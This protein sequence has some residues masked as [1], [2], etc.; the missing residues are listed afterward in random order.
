MD[1]ASTSRKRSVGETGGSPQRPPR[2]LTGTALSFDLAQEV[3]TLHQEETWHRGD[4]NART[5]IEEPG[6]RVVLPVLR[7]GSRVREHRNGR[8][9]VIPTLA[10][11]IRAQSPA[12][13][14]GPVGSR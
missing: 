7:A 9:V 11:H 8:W 10:G 13:T 6:L 5:L 14:L 3:A 1:E 4:R 2:R 12:G